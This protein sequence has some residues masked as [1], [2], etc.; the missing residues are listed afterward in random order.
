MRIYRHSLTWTIMFGVIALMFLRLPPM[1]AKQ[2]AVVNTYSALV[3]VDALARQQYVEPIADDRLVEGAIRGMMLQ[4][5]PYSGYV[6]PEELP[7]FERHSRGQFS[8]VGIELGIQDGRLTVIAPIEGSPAARAGVMPGD[9]I[10]SIDGKDLKRRSV[11][12]VEGMLMGAVGTQVRVRLQHPVTSEPRELTLTRVALSLKT[13]RGFRRT[14]DHRWDYMIDPQDGIGY[15]RVSDF[16][17]STCTDFDKAIGQLDSGRLR[18]LILDLRFNPGGFMHQAIA[19]ADRFLSDG[20]IV[21]TVTRRNAVDEYRAEADPSDLDIPV[22][23]LMNSASASA[24]EIVAGA[25]QA[26]K[27]ATVVG[28]RSFGKGSVQHLIHLVGQKA[29]IKLTVAYYRLPDNRII[30]RTAD[31][32]DTDVWGILPDVDVRLSR[33]EVRQVQ[34][35]RRLLDMPSP[36]DSAAAVSPGDPSHDDHKQEI[37]RDRQLEASLT[38]IRSYLNDRR[39]NAN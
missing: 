15:I 39:T 30:H 5:D 3:E 4:L 27:R 36:E 32:E 1:V 26:R 12:D 25:L 35:S 6:S 18:G 13:V 20:V 33:D 28:E 24:S 22:V 9:L 38:L 7:A 11:F 8:G 19:M 17:E 23:V 34:Q 2:D 31:N 10:L 16:R 29:A 21:S 37:T 14:A